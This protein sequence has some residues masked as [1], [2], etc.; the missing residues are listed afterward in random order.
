MTS[1]S[2]G[3]SQYE[4]GVLTYAEVDAIIWVVPALYGVVCVVEQF[5]FDS[6]YEDALGWSDV[7]AEAKVRVRPKGG[8]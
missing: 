7:G 2:R 4:C 8:E 1:G 5:N 6:R 3:L